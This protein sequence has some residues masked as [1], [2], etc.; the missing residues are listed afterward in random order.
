MSETTKFESC[1][2]LFCAYVDYVGKTKSIKKLF[3]KATSKGQWQERNLLYESYDDFIKDKENKIAIAQSFKRVDTPGMNLASMETFLKKNPKWFYSSCIIAVKIISSLSGMS[4]PNVSLTKF[5]R[6]LNGPGIK[7]DYVRGDQQV[8]VII[9]KLFSIVKKNT[10]SK[11]KILKGMSAV[12]FG[13]VNKWNPADIYYATDKASLSLKGALK[14]AEKDKSYGFPQLNDLIEGLMVSADLLPLS[15]KKQTNPANAKIELVNFN[16]AV[17]KDRISQVQ[18]HSIKYEKYTPSTRG[19]KGDD[20]ELPSGDTI[21]RDIYINICN[22]AKQKIGHIQMRHDP[23]GTGSW[24]VDLK[25]T[26][27]EA[28]G[29]SVVSYK[30]FADIWHLSDPQSAAKFRT[31]YEKGCGEF[32]AN[33]YS[34]GKRSATAKNPPKEDPDAKIPVKKPTKNKKLNGDLTYFG[35][36]GLAHH[37]PTKNK[38]DNNDIRKAKEFSNQKRLWKIPYRGGM[39]Y[40]DKKGRYKS[41]AYDF[42]KGEISAI[43]IMNRVGPLIDN[44]FKN[45]TKL[46][47]GFIQN[48]YQYVS[49]RHPDSSKFVIAK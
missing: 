1:Q 3:G 6:R 31:A 22:K 43:T 18:Y 9:G 7:M 23:S 32:L 42:Q 10:E 2:A 45:N 41:S 14:K 11:S 12:P 24:K 26:A 34:T 28:R 16:K 36:G 33:V 17:K 21:A 15:L 40:N 29:G 8:M 27:S 39:G 25:Y 46:R 20:K 5:A 47:D 48:L 38:K 44:W 19:S 13:D 37:I 4:T 35:V 30:I 49:S